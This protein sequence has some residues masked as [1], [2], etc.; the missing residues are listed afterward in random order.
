R[1]LIQPD[2]SG[3]M[4]LMAPG[5]AEGFNYYWFG[6]AAILTVTVGTMF[7]MWLGE[8]IDEYGIGNGISL[9]NKA[10]II[11]RIPAATQSLLFE[12][13]TGP[14]G[15]VSRIKPSLFTLGSG[16]GD[17]SFEKFLLL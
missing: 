13:T 10:G 11:G 15:P 16:T 17:I 14:D 6:L 1:G 5:Y 3:G 12:T 9:I 7:L 8:Q 2:N 4:G